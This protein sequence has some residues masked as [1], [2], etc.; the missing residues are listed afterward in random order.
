MLILSEPVP[1]PPH[2]W[3]QLD[4]CIIHQFWI[5]SR[6]PFNQQEYNFWT[7]KVKKKKIKQHAFLIILL[8]Y[9]KTSILYINRFISLKKIK[10][11]S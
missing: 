5:I 7:L 3:V 11:A 8:R 10:S 2:L 6:P 1:L 9:R 4:N